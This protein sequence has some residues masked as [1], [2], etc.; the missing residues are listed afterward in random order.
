[1]PGT[2]YAGAEF[3][4]GTR[5]PLREATGL[6]PAAYVDPAF[7]AE[8]QQRLF[9]RAWVAVGTAP[10]VAAPGRMLVR[11]VGRRSILITRDGDGVLRGFLNS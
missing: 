6:D 2:D 5:A 1:M 4:R 7:H 10:E 11:R 8:E 9:E 3:W